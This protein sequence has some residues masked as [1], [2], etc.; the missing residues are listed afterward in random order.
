MLGDEPYRFLTGHPVKMIEARKIYGTRIGPQG[1]LSA[2]IKVVV[3]V[4]QGQFAQRVIDGFAVTASGVV[5]LRNRAPTIPNF[6]NGKDMI[7]VPLGFHIEEQ[8]R[9][10]ENAQRSGGK[11]G[12]LKAVAGEFP[13]HPARRP[14]GVSEVVGHPVEQALDAD[15]RAQCTQ[16][17]QLGGREY[18]GLR[19][20]SR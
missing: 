14:A 15:R 3:E 16:P 12:A 17:A 20:A 18:L 6:E 8:S 4:A 13:Q 7:G 10:A 1:T 5:R 19:G 2:K 9:E 11:D